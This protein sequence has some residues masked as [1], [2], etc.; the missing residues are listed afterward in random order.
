[1]AVSALAS[2]CSGWARKGRRTARLAVGIGVRL[3]HDAAVL[4]V[5]VVRRELDGFTGLGVEAG[6]Q[7]DCA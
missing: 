2:E 3:A 5:F 1:M 6:H 4:G 7:Y